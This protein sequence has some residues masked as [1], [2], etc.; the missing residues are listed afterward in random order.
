[1]ILGVVTVAVVLTSFS[2]AAPVAGAWLTVAVA[3][4]SPPPERRRYL[5]AASGVVVVT[6]CA[7]LPFVVHRPKSLGE[8]WIERG[9]MANYASIHSFLHNV[10][11]MTAGLGKWFLNLPVGAR[12]EVSSFVATTYVSAVAVMILGSSVL[13]IAWWGGV[14]RRDPWLLMS[15]ATLTL[16]VA[17]ALVDLLPLGDGRTDLVLAPFVVILAS[18]AVKWLRGVLRRT[19]IV[20]VAL[21]ASLVLMGAWSTSASLHRTVTYPAT[22]LRGLFA[23]LRP[24]LYPGDVIVVP[25]FLSFSWA[26]ARLSPYHVVIGG[27]DVWP[28]GFR[29]V[30]DSSLVLLPTTYSGE[31]TE[32]RSLP[33]RYKRVWYI[34]YTAGVWNP[35]EVR[36]GFGAKVPMRNYTRETLE[37]YGWRTSFIPLYALNCYAEPMTYRGK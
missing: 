35:Q 22:D 31:A 27:P 21:V 23:K 6:G 17:A 15:A 18:Y 11:Q 30:S 37:D 25:T 13:T 1:L 12:F 19:R 32:L 33:G 7:V 36:P 14:R 20:N 5:L 4:W 34:G 29:P 8:K 2:L 3:T 26:Q 24:N 16:A 28:Q 9:Y 10:V